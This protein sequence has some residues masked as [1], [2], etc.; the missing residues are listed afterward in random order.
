VEGGA[1]LLGLKNQIVGRLESDLSLSSQDNLPP[2]GVPRPWTNLEPSQVTGLI[3][4]SPSKTTAVSGHAPCC[5]GQDP[6]RSTRNSTIRVENSKCLATGEKPLGGRARVPMVCE[7]DGPYADLKIS[8]RADVS[9][10][11]IL[12][13]LSKC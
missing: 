1:K 2:P 11:L 4:E 8:K 9:K 5:L 12:Q 13:K 7:T 6:N 10:A 3:N